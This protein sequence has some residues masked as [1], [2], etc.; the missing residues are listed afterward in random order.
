MDMSFIAGATGYTGQALVRHFAHQG[1]P[2]LAHVRP[3]SRQGEALARLCE[4]SSV[5]V[6]EIPW[7]LDAITEVLVTHK[8]ST[9]FALIGVTRAG[10]KSEARRTGEQVNYDTVDYGLTRMLVA[11]SVQSG[12]RPTFVY[13]SSKGV[14]ERAPGAYLQA[15]WKAEQALVHSNLPYIIAR[16]SFIS[17][18]DR[19]ESRPMERIAARMTRI[20]GGS[21]SAIGVSGPLEKYG[22][23]SADELAH[24]LGTLASKPHN[25]GRIY[26]AED[27]RSYTSD[28]RAGDVS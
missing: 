6:C 11:A 15:R 10:A 23:M 5:R 20:L 21:L 12:R 13:L 4:G 16:P 1:R 9:V 22:P 19:A 24:A 17:G 18:A 14:S 25:A 7:E 3:G 26:E 8:V 28:E 2:A 27:L